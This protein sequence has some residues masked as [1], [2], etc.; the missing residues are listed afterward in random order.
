MQMCHGKRKCSIRAEASTFGRPC[1]PQSRN[2]LKVIHTCVPR[3]V[4]KKKFQGELESDE[5]D[6]NP[7]E[8]EDRTND[9]STSMIIEHSAM[10][11]SS[12]HPF[13][14]RDPHSTQDSSESQ[15]LFNSNHD[16]SSSSPTGGKDDNFG[17]RSSAVQNSDTDIHEVGVDDGQSNG[18]SHNYTGSSEDIR[19][20]NLISQSINAYAFIE[21]NSHTF[22]LLIAISMLSV[23][24]LLLFLLLI[25]LVYV[26][27]K[28]NKKVQEEQKMKS[29]T[30]RRASGLSDIDEL[31]LVLD[32]TEYVHL[33]T[34][35]RRSNPSSS[36][37]GSGGLAKNNR[38]VRYS[39]SRNSMLGRQESD[40][41]PRSFHQEHESD[42]HFFF[43]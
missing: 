21:R 13:E 27:H 36:T 11:P 38:V 35:Q 24:L 37:F 19:F 14:P 39:N 22:W 30:I 23:F 2:Y 16:D 33:S 31:S 20:I 18:G 42:I 43:G 8:S 26:R 9:D 5:T 28:G 17:A 12:N 6:D 10:I 15:V 4:L 1:K 3:K 41:S 32:P 25:R 7:D 29:S 34:I 40:T